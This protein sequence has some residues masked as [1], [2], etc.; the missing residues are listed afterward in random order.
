VCV[1]VWHLFICQGDAEEFGTVYIHLKCHCIVKM[2]DVLLMKYGLIELR[3]M[4]SGGLVVCSKQI[5]SEQV[6]LEEA[7]RRR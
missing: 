7:I 2:W 4:S 1:C 6:S 3:R 5:A